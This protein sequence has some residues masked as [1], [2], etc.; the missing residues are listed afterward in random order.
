MA[1]FFLP[2]AGRSGHELERS[3]LLLREQAEAL[4]GAVS[5]ARR[6]QALDCRCHGEDLCLS[7]GD[8]DTRNGQTI[9][10][11]LQLGRDTY[12]IHHVPPGSERTPTPPT[13]LQ[14]TDVYAVTD[15]D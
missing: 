11:I 6:I 13:M 5:R 8:T 1:P 12:T 4:T 2:P 15:F 9:A 10:A 3:Y 14:R 7:V